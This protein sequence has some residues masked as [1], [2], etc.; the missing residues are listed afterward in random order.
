MRLVLTLLVTVLAIAPVLDAT[1]SIPAGVAELAREAS[2]VVL[3]RV[4]RVTAVQDPATGRVE[5][6]VTV[7]AERVAKGTARDEVVVV[8]PGGT[9]GRYRTVFVGAP[10]FEPGESVVLFLAPAVRGGWRVLGLGGGVFRVADLAEG[11]LVI[12]PPIL[13]QAR[14]PAGA[15]GRIVRG[16]QAGQLVTVDEFLARV[17]DLLDRPPARGRVP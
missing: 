1:T 9:A 16:A 10:D 2:L 3:G 8:V 7:V 17:S 5:R 14:S 11:R 15:S 6:H 13:P 4:G 12:P